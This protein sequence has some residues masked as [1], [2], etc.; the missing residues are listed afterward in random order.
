MTFLGKRDFFVTIGFSRQVCADHPVKAVL[1][2]VNV[3][4]CYWLLPAGVRKS[5]RLSCACVRESNVLLFAS[6]CKCLQIGPY[7][8]DREFGSTV[9]LLVFLSR[10]TQ[11][12]LF[13]Q[14]R[15]YVNVLFCYW[16][17][18]A[19]VRNF[20]AHAVLV[21]VKVL[22]RFWLLSADIRRLVS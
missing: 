18:S 8:Q 7:P 12:G 11:V 13:M 20:F 17:L 19:G 21:Y 16:L 10:C 15:V 1:V 4:F 5:V 22:F 3:M 2:Y 14:D 6:L 9:L